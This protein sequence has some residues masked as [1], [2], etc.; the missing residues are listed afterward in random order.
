MCDLLC[1]RI[2]CPLYTPFFFF[3]D[4]ATTEIYTLSLH[5][6]LPISADPGATNRAA[7]DVPTTSGTAP[8]VVATTGT[9]ACIASSI[10]FGNPSLRDGSTN[11][12]RFRYKTSTLYTCPRKR[13][14]DCN[15]RPRQR[16]SRRA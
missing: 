9:S 3:N 16:A 10:V 4:T 5:D 7:D 2:L 15:P 6:A 11:R 12:S 14:H 8:T 1:M 13:T